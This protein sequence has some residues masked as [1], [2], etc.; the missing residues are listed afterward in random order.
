MAF[1]IPDR[2]FLV[3]RAKAVA[4]PTE[5]CGFTAMVGKM[6]PLPTPNSLEY[7]LV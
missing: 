7:Q 6:A 1:L 2:D 3:G 4:L 5:K